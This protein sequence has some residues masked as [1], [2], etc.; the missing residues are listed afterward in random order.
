M[1]IDEYNPH[2]LTA[3]EREFVLD[4]EAKQKEESVPGKDYA[5]ALKLRVE[6]EL[7]ENLDVASR[8]E[9][10]LPVRPTNFFTNE[11]EK[12]IEAIEKVFD[13][14]IIYGVIYERTRLT[15][16]LH[17]L[18]VDLDTQ[19]YSA[20]H[21]IYRQEYKLSA[22]SWDHDIDVRLSDQSMCEEEGCYDPRMINYD[23]MDHTKKSMIDINSD[24]S[25]WYMRAVQPKNSDKKD[26]DLS[27]FRVVTSFNW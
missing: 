12:K 22:I 5:K 25:I 23:S 2:C 26:L 20:W 8:D 3:D 13:D 16:Y 24:S 19:A 21:Y 9:N 17:F 4:T 7:W 10:F 15:T 27:D 11:V 1:R 14:I 6:E 18:Y